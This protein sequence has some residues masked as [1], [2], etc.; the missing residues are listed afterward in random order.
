MLVNSKIKKTILIHVS[1]LDKL[2]D[3]LTDDLFD[4][5]ITEFLNEV[6]SQ[7]QLDPDFNDMVKITMEL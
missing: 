5:D 3:H 1:V 4:N 2:Y 7:D 6:C